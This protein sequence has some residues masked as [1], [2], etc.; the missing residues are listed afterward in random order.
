MKRYAVT[1]HHTEHP[2]KR[3]A[4][5]FSVED[6]A[7]YLMQNPAVAIG[8]ATPCI[9]FAKGEWSHVEEVLSLE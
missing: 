4:D 7:L 8:V 5:F 3:Q 6:G 1:T 9:V 2:V